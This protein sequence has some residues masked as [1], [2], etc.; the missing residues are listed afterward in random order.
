[1]IIFDIWKINGGDVVS[2][3]RWKIEPSL[4]VDCLKYGAIGGSVASYDKR[5]RRG[6]KDKTEDLGFGF[7][8][9]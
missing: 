2:I 8:Q 7:L 3:S 1:M 4:Q 6:A 5:T 9:P